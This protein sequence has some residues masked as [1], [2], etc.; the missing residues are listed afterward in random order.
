MTNEYGMPNVLERLIE[1]SLKKDP[2]VCVEMFG[3]RVT[4]KEVMDLIAKHESRF[5]KYHRLS[6]ELYYVFVDD[7]RMIPMSR[8][9]ESS[10]REL[11]AYLYDEATIEGETDE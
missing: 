4:P 1:D 3:L 9:L 7:K 8:E 2:D 6:K 5:D 11:K 10:F